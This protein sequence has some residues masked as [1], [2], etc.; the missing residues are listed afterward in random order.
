MC[1]PG[2]VTEVWGLENGSVGKRGCFVI[3]HPPGKTKGLCGFAP[4]PPFFPSLSLLFPWNM[5]RGGKRK[6]VKA[7]WKRNICR[8]RT[9]F[10]AKCGVG[11]TLKLWGQIIIGRPKFEKIWNLN[12]FSFSKVNR[13]LEM[14]RG[15]LEIFWSGAVVSGIYTQQ[16]FCGNFYFS[17][18]VCTKG[19]GREPFFT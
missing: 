12:F 8:W 14:R 6:N 3:L 11:R 2:R 19:R 13:E 10:P 16:R 4:C 15:A 9:H 7:N 18:F 1:Q 17:N 5:T